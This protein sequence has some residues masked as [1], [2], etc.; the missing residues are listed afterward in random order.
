MFLNRSKIVVES[1]ISAAEW[2]HDRQCVAPLTETLRS[3][4]RELSKENFYRVP[5]VEVPINYADFGSETI[6]YLPKDLYL[7]PDLKR[8]IAGIV[9]SKLGVAFNVSWIETGLSPYA[10]FS[11]P[12]PPPPNSVLAADIVDALCDASDTAPIIGVGQANEYVTADLENDSPHI[13][14]SAGSGGG[15]S[16]LAK[17]IICQ[18]INRG[19]G[20]VVLDFKRTSH[21]WIMGIPGVLYAR[22]IDEIHDAL[23]ALGEEAHRRNKASDNPD[24]VL[25]PRLYLVC[26]EMN[27]TIFKLNE[28]WLENKPRGGSKISPA[29]A[30]LRDILFMGRSVLINVIAIAQMMTARAI[31]GPEARENFGTRCLTRY[32][33]NAWKMLA[34][35]VWPAPK[36]SGVLG[37]W[38]IV[39]QGQA[40][41]TQVVYFTD[42][43]AREWATPGA[44]HNCLT[45]GR[46]PIQRNRVTLSEAI[47]VLPDV[48]PS[49][50]ALRKAS[51]RPGFPQ[52]VERSHGTGHQYELSE[53]V[54][55]SARR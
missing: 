49:L 38:Q 30:A 5:I 53:I 50:D 47:R 26:E 40:Q 17:A 3:S 14:V 6:V 8:K 34:P 55:W 52:P 7:E 32:S 15:K 46:V 18:G 4:V 42:D 48:A 29:I 41:A 19:A 22:D 24:D 44:R 28:Y 31:G 54:E 13:L 45:S 37:R 33:L 16:V 11:P 51:Q 39:S 21:K 2:K 43:Q 12:L 25:G 20:T 9:K 23:V 1:G 10:V 35:E 27:A 36:K